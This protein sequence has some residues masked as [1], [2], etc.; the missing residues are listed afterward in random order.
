MLAESEATTL[1]CAEGRIV[2]TTNKCGDAFVILHPALPQECGLI[3]GREW[4]GISKHGRVEKAHAHAKKQLTEWQN[5]S[6]SKANTILS[7]TVCLGTGAASQ[8]AQ[9]GD[10]VVHRCVE[11]QSLQ[12]NPYEGKLVSATSAWADASS[13]KVEHLASI[14]RAFVAKRSMQKPPQEASDNTPSRAPEVK[15]AKRRS[16]GQR[17]SD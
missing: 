17:R 9:S 14:V 16:R 6:R 12:N 2:R 11:W 7:V 1:L 8:D 15:K 13:I 5:Q 4:I 3:S 10:R